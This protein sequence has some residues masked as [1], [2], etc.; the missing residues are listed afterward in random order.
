MVKLSVPC[1]H[2]YD[3]SYV[4]KIEGKW[5]MM[6]YDDNEGVEIDYCPHCGKKLDRDG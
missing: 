5:V 6:G 4:A 1:K 2:E 3:W